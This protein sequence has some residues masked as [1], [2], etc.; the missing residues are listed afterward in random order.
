MTS[1]Q[2]THGYERIIR[3]LYRVRGPRDYPQLPPDMG[4]HW[5]ARAMAA[6]AAVPTEVHDELHFDRLSE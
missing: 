4:P 1:P 2:D 5:T 3:A 6:L